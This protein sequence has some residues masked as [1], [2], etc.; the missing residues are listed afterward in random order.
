MAPALRATVE[1]LLN[2]KVSEAKNKDLDSNEEVLGPL[3][4]ENGNGR[5]AAEQERN[6]ED[7]YSI[8]L[9]ALTAS[10]KDRDDIEDNSDWLLTLGKSS[11]KEDKDSNN[12][13][14]L[15][16]GTTS[17]GDRNRFKDN[18]LPNRLQRQETP[19]NYTLSD[20]DRLSPNYLPIL[21]RTR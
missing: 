4:K 9:S 13:S 17:I 20:D 12:S 1:P 10:D 5:E 18:N 21:I 3:L 11:N 6:K 2:T 8:A 14:L 16:L 19:P 7:N 15:D